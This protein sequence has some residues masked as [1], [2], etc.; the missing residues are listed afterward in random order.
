M[1]VSEIVRTK[2]IT[3]RDTDTISK[4]ISTLTEHDICGAPVVDGGGN[5]VGIIS[6]VNILRAMKTIYRELKMVYPSIPVMGISFVEL[7]KRKDVFR[8]LKDITDKK[9]E[10]LME[11]NIHKISDKD[12]V[13][14][15]IPILTREKGDM[16]PV[17]TD[18]GTLV[19][20]ITRG[21]VLEV[22]VEGSK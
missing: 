7:Q 2:V 20:I 4:A 5:L 17:V 19:G 6:E 21:D 11:K 12:L 16:L 8:A 14:D 10:E 3:L 18:K 9:V 22:L 1:R 13:E 15:I